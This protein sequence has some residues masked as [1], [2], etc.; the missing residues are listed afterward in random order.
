MLSGRGLP[1][2]DAK[3]E[4][5]RLAAQ[6]RE[7]DRLRAESWERQPLEEDPAEVL[8]QRTIQRHWI[9]VGLLAAVAVL[10]FLGGNTPGLMA[11]IVASALALTVAVRGLKR[12]R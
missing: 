11:G 9:L 6:A 8:E 4:G 7:A 3:I 1:N 12:R 2:M 10:F 5:D